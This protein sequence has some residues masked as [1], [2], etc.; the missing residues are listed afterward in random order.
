ML[1]TAFTPYFVR[2]NICFRIS[3][4]ESEYRNP[5]FK[6]L[7][8]NYCIGCLAIGLIIG[9]GSTVC[10]NWMLAEIVMWIRF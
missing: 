6:A 7:R 5:R 1:A 4:P 8:R 3:I 2:K 10:Y 9:I